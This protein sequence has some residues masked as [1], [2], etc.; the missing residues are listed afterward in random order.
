MKFGVNIE[1]LRGNTLGADFPGGLV[2][3][4]TLHDLLVNLPADINADVPGTV[5]GRGVRQTIFGA[6]FQDDTH[7]RPNLSVNWGLRYEMASIITEEANKLSNLRVLSSAPPNP[8]LGSPYIMN[9]TKRNFEP[10]VG[11]AWDPFRDG[12]TSVAGGFGLFDVLPLP[13]E[14]GSGVDGS[15]P[16]DIS[17]SGTNLPQ[18]SFILG[19]P[20]A[21]GAYLDTANIHRYYVMQFNPR[22][23]YVMQWNFNIQRQLTAGTSLMVGYVG[24]RGRHMRFQADDVNMVYPTL[25]P[26]GYLWPVPNT[27]P[28]PG[29]GPSTCSWPVLNPAMGRTQMAIFDG[30]YDYN[31]MQVQV[32]KAMAHGLQI[33]GSYTWSKNIDDG[34]G[35]V[36]SDPFRN[37]ISTLLW[38]C[39][40]CRR[41]LS[42]QDQRHNL[43]ANYVWD[44]PTP[45]SFGALPKAILGNW[46]TNGILT[47]QS[48][49]PF[50]VLVAGDPLGENNTDAY[51]YPDRVNGPGCNNPVNPQNADRYVKLEC[52]AAPNPSYRLGTSGRNALIGPGL[53][54]MDFS[55]FKNIPLPKISESFK[56]QFRAELFNVF[57]RPNFT[58]P[59]DN[60][61]ILNPDGTQAAS[62]SGA[63]TLTNTT[64]RQIQFALKLTW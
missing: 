36:A 32:K 44:I 10:R 23:N 18:G 63:I 61:V 15:F 42:D 48:G 62:N 35:S 57:N 12:K 14:M 34:G 26:Q 7:L 60:R 4:A 1:R 24:A 47:I 13:V 51:Q 54:D 30:I 43:T 25:T 53:I 52:F 27:A 16:Y 28:C 41:G 37:S 3:F 2:D 45:K 39:E 11:F 49:T 6:Y 38:F 56:A 20:T 22:R 59:N 31:G 9:P 64:A 17:A 58:S 19:C 29:G 50:T 55:L 5:T 33:E 46:E 40:R 21:C 8:F